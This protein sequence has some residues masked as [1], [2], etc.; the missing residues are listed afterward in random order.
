MGGD[1]RTL[2]GSGP[3]SWSHDGTAAGIMDLCGNIWEWN[4]GMKIIDGRIYVVGED[5][6]AVAVA[7]QVFAGEERGASHVAYG[8]G[9]F[10]PAFCR[11]EC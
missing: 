1:G 7:A 6:T 5:G 10:A 11:G 3:N 8:S 9:L 2:T 4:Q